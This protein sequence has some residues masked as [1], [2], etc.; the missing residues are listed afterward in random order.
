MTF[1]TVSMASVVLVWSIGQVSESQ[2]VFSS[3]INARV[4]RAMERF[5][6]EDVQFLSAGASLTTPAV[7]CPAGS[8]GCLLVY[9]RNVGSIQLVVDAAYINNQLA[10]QSTYSSSSNSPKL[11]LGMQQLGYIFVRS[12]LTL[13]VGTTYQIASASTRGNS[14]VVSQTF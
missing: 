13:S 8:N 1:V 2:N 5:V 6:I 3:A 11:S 7:T 9:I 10:D 12:P 14:V 4:E